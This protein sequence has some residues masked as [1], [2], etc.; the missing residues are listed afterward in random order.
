MTTE[1][2][3][4]PNR[5]DPEI[6]RFLMI[7][8]GILLIVAG[9]SFFGGLDMWRAIRWLAPVRAAWGDVRGVL[10]GGA[11]IIGGL[12]FIIYRDK[13]RFSMPSGEKRL[14]RSNE[15]KML[16]GVIGGLAE[17][18]GTDPTLL[19]LIVVAIAMLTGVWGVAVA[20]VIAAIVIPP[21]PTGQ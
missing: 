8:F 3:R 19:R 5:P 9:L 12:T 7:A 13:L 4:G 16:T 10:I 14:Y 15:S 18:V 11:L 1:N 6:K 2:Q 17:Y 20:Y 21:P